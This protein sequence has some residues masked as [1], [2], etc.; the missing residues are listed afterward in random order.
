[1]PADRPPVPRELER[2]VL[3]ESGHRCAIPTCQAIPV[4]LAHIVPWSKVREHTFD[5]LIALCPTCHRRYDGGSIDRMS[6]LEYKRNLRLLA[7]RY[8]VDV[9][10]QR[11]QTIAAYCALRSAFDA[12]DMTIDA[13]ID[14]NVTKP[15]EQEEQRL[16]DQCT[17]AGKNAELSRRQ[18]AAVSTPDTKWLAEWVFDRYRSLANHAVDGLLP[19]THPGA[20]KHEDIIELENDLLSSVSED[21]DMDARALWKLSRQA[22]KLGGTGLRF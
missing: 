8:A 9:E 3:V 14:A 4:D 12:W 6:M 10:R 21:V 18:L 11:A 19:S 17:N 16:V 15:D 13:V 22:W 20:D 2:Q 5:N 1:M 7:S